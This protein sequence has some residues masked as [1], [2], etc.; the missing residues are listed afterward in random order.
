MNNWTIF[1]TYHNDPIHL[2]HLKLSNS[3]NTIIPL[4][5]KNNLPKKNAW[6]NSDLL[7][8]NQIKNYIQDI[9]TNNIAIIE[10]DVL[11]K[12]NLPNIHIDSIFGKNIK[13]PGKHNWHWFREIHKLENL[14][15]S[16]LGITPFALIYMNSEHLMRWV[17]REYDS[18]YLKNISNELRIGT[19][20]NHC[21]F[22]IKSMNFP[23][24]FSNVAMKNK[25]ITEEQLLL[26]TNSKIYHPI[27]NYYA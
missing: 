14:K 18:L 15:N 20:F 5:I 6:K 4:N 7:I 24:V 1:Y 26:K 19:I 25:R 22:S 27:K 9:K 21:K 11:V 12:E 2:H 23:N 8:R 13:Y 16:A 3:N 10:Y 17:H